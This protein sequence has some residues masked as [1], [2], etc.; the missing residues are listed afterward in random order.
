ME[1]SWDELETEIGTLLLV[2]DQLALC[3]LY[4]GDEQPQL[5]KRLTR[6]YGQFQLRRAKNLTR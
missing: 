6:R 1:L 5:M 2:A 4:Y 3:A